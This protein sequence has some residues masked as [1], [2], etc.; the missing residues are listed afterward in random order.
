[1]PLSFPFVV[2]KNFSETGLRQLLLSQSS[3]DCVDGCID[4]VIAWR[5][6]ASKEARPN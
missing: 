6:E 4:V 3:D 5:G 1:M 2:L